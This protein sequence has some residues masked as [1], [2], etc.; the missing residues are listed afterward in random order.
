MVGVRCGCNRHKQGAIARARGGW[1][2][3]EA[4]SWREMRDYRMGKQEVQQGQGGVVLWV[5][6]K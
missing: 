1:A 3:E 6:Q 4:F 2:Q 5:V